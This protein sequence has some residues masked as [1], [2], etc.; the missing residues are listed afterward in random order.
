MNKNILFTFPVLLTLVCSS[1]IHNS[2]IDKKETLSM[3]VTEVDTLSCDTTNYTIELCPISG[4]DLWI[5]SSDMRVQSNLIMRLID[6]YNSSVV[7]NSIITDF[8]LVMRFESE[9]ENAIVG[10]MDMDITHVKDPETSSRL[11]AYKKE[12][13]YLLTANSDTINKD[14]YNPWIEYNTLYKYLVQKYNVSTFGRIDESMYKRTFHNPQSVPE[15]SKL[16]IRRGETN[17]VAELKGKYDNAKDFDARCI[18]AIELAHAYEADMD[19]WSEDDYRNPAI[20]IME[21]LM[22][23][24]KYSIYLNELWLKWRTLYQDSEG[25]SKDSEIPNHLYNEYRKTC[26][27]S[28]LTYIKEHPNDMLAINNYLVMAFE[29]NILREGVYSYGNQYILDKYKLFREKYNEVD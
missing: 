25:A 13:L 2:K 19:S 3:K 21:S 24:Q 27:W 18:Y 20:P 12:M 6:A 10:I 14:I 11:E 8:D 28:T 16:K 15:W 26:I 1:C 7:M 23:E 9:Y 5:D 22:K 4:M 29:E 17:M